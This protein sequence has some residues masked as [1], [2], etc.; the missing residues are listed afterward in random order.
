MTDDCGLRPGDSVESLKGIG[1]ARSRQLGAAGIDTVADLLFHI[2]MRWED[3]RRTISVAEIEEDG[4]AVAVR[5][6]VTG[7]VSRRARRRGLTILEAVFE[8]ST[9]QLPVLWFNP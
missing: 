4:S 5:G 2:P 9:G 8:D 3:R 1:A 7:L 6:R